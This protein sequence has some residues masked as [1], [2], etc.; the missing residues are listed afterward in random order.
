MSFVE[1]SKAANQIV[2]TIFKPE[3]E[4]HT[5]EHASTSAQ[6]L[7]NERHKLFLS[8]IPILSHL[9]ANGRFSLFV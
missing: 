6:A 9:Y 5:A 7:I 1:G 3:T 2:T 4:Q 8:A